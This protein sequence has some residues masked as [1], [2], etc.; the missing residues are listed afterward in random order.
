MCPSD[1][2]RLTICALVEGSSRTILTSTFALML[3][4]EHRARGDCSWYWQSTSSGED[5]N[6]ARARAR[7]WR[8][9]DSLTSFMLTDGV[10]G[11]EPKLQTDE[12]A[13]V[14]PQHTQELANRPSY[15]GGILRAYAMVKQVS[16]TRLQWVDGEKIGGH[17]L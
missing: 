2:T 5:P 8:W 1:Q 11:P 9:H 12:E 10:R 14:I 17:P 3:D 15:C 4:L 7:R 13:R 6:E 16:L